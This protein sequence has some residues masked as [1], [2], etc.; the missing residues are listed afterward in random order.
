MWSTWAEWGEALASHTGE[1]GTNTIHVKFTL[2]RPDQQIS[3]RIIQ[4]KKLTEKIKWNDN[5]KNTLD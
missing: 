2:A 3:K 1:R 4:N 5:L